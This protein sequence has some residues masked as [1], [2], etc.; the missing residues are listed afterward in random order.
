MLLLAVAV[1]VDASCVAG[2]PWCNL[3]RSIEHL[4]LVQR[5]ASTLSDMALDELKTPAHSD[6]VRVKSSSNS[7]MAA[8]APTSAWPS[9][10]TSTT[11]SIAI[12][13]FVSS[14]SGG[15]NPYWQPAAPESRAIADSLACYA[16]RHDYRY[17]IQDIDDYV[18]AD[19]DT[20]VGASCCP[21]GHFFFDRHCAAAMVLEHDPSIEWL[22]VLDA[23]VSAMNTTLSLDRFVGKGNSPLAKVVREKGIEILH[24]E[25]TNNG[26]I[27][28]F[29]Y[30]MR[31]TP[32]VHTYL[33]RWASMAK[34][35]GETAETAAPPALVEGFR[36]AYSRKN[37]AE[38]LREPFA[39]TNFDNGALHALF[40][41]TVRPEIAANVTE[42][43]LG[44]RP[45]YYSSFVRCSMAAINGDE[46]Q[47]VFPEARV[48][49]LR[50]RHG[51]T[52][53]S[54]DSADDGTGIVTYA[55]TLLH[56]T[57]VDASPFTGAVDC[58]AQGATLSADPNRFVT[59]L[60]VA[61]ASVIRWDGQ[62]ASAA[63]KAVVI[64]DVAECWP[65]CPL[66][67]GRDWA[68]KYVDRC[69]FCV[70]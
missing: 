40:L 62:L 60:A 16:S 28:A 5:H 9:T 22:L 54:G 57:K 35:W 1:A 30:L 53:A 34:T 63:Q 67:L 31:N 20:A 14:T 21:N 19:C 27:G 6:T 44:I 23:D 25:R 29:A 50:K 39:G 36:K 10:I 8:A 2:D 12:I 4:S 24:Q 33:R 52:A 69:S 65:D 64:T 68:K 55:D 43:C 59:E 26:E 56:G 38:G 13:Q 17:S 61:H 37:I 42:H 70:S 49:L 66:E 46:G 15:R 41:S 18:T 58:E 32:H 7:Q 47:R 45:F 51:L 3:D 48:I 11:S